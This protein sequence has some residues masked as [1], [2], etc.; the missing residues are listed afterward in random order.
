MALFPG[1]RCF[2]ASA[3]TCALFHIYL[4]RGVRLRLNSRLT[5]EG[6]TFIVLAISALLFPFCFN[7]KIAYLCS[8]I[9]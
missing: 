8:R 6:E 3:M 4:P 2:R 1:L 5:V 7:A 9:K